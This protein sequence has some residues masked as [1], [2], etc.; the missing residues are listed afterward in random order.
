MFQASPG[1]GALVDLFRRVVRQPAANSLAVSIYE[2]LPN[3]TDFTEA[4]A[5][6]VR[7]YNFAPIGDARLYHSPLA[8]PDN[9]DPRALQHLGSQA[10]D[11]AHALLAADPLPAA[12][13]DV[14][15]SDVL[16]M[17]TVAHDPWVGWAL[18]AL[19]AGLVVAIARRRRGEWSWRGVAL[20][21]AHGVAGLVATA[22]ALTVL[23][24]LSR[25][26]E[27]ADYYDRLAALPR[28]EWQALLV[29]LAVL[30]AMVVG[31]RGGLERWLAFAGVTLLLAT[32][33]QAV[34]PGGS[35]FFA[36]PLLLA[37]S[38]V[39][40]AS[41][42]RSA[43]GPLARAAFAAAAVL[44]LAFLAALGHFAMLSIGAGLPAVL[45]VLLPQAWLLLA[46]LLPR[47][48]RGGWWVALAL[49]L[50]AFAVALWVRL[51][52]VAASVP[53]YSETR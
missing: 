50:A 52:P 19:G 6:G 20:A 51:D 29:L 14:V 46:P 45:V 37:T 33:V 4:L 10:L 16:G 44:G 17:A 18:L 3:S 28:L 7:G 49:L 12:A 21:G 41:T 42:R 1:N 32:A 26:P 15:F 40:A 31:P 22:L 23:N 5:R 43:H 35:P 13:P 9:V 24:A 38:V 11:L 39:A 48:H 36:W 34:L 2:R 27:G 30:A 53:V 47:P 25:G 8:T